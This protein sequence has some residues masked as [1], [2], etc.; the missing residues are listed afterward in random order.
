MIDKKTEAAH[1]T[2]IA[3]VLEGDARAQGINV[4]SCFDQKPFYMICNVAT[5]VGWQIVDKKIYSQAAKKTIKY[6]F[7]WFNISNDYNHEVND[8][9]IANQ[10]CL[11]YQMMRNTRNMKWRWTLWLW[12]FEVSLV[13]SYH[14]YFCYHRMMGIDPDYNHYEF[15]N[16][17]DMGWID[18]VNHWHTPN[19][20]H[21]ELIKKV[22]PINTRGVK[23]TWQ[24]KIITTKTICPDTGSLCC[25][26]NSTLNH[27][28][29]PVD[30]NKNTQC[31]LHMW[32]ARADNPKFDAN[33]TNPAGAQACVMHCPTCHV[34]LCMECFSLFHE[35]EFLLTCIDR[36]LCKSK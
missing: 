25:R 27:L 14:I 11:V 4:A 35:E 34:H 33:T 18:P 13:N 10:L 20:L 7:L 24:C 5:E 21:L 26:L 36:I 1:S 9:D 2:L 23:H 32:A 17:V 8:N 30:K 29:Q 15:M 6:Q 16:A 28:P 12:R 22:S 19:R 3:A 31:Q